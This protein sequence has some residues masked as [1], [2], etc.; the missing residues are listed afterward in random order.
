MYVIVLGKIGWKI[1]QCQKYTTFVPS[2]ALNWE[3]ADFLL[4]PV[5]DH[6]CELG[7]VTQLC[8]LQFHQRSLQIRSFY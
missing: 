1:S 8:G 5:T 6:W 2:I 3:P 7:S 4:F